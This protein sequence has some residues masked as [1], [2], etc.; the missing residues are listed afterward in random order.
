MELSCSLNDTTILRKLILENPELPLLI[1]VGEEAYCPDYSYTMAFS[2]GG[3]IQELSLYNDE[4]WMDYDDY[5]DKLT[6][7][8]EYEEEYKNLPDEEYDKMI[9]EKMKE[10]EFVKAIVIHVG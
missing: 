7:D 10:V 4:M 2:S 8:L 9:D 5:K 1:F 6:D 3:E